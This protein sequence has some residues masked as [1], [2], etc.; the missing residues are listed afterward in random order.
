MIGAKNEY[1][2]ANTSGV[3]IARHLILKTHGYL[4]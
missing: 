4:D 3:L 2:Q 1:P